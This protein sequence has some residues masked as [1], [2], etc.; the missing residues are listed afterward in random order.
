M[1]YLKILPGSL[2][3]LLPFTT[4]IPKLFPIRQAIMITV[5]AAN[6]EGPSM[7]MIVIVVVIVVCD[8][9]VVTL[10][11]LTEGI[12]LCTRY[13]A[14]VPDSA[15]AKLSKVSIFQVRRL[16]QVRRVCLRNIIERNQQQQFQ[17][18]TLEPGPYCLATNS[19]FIRI[20]SKQQVS[21]LVLSYTRLV[22]GER[23]PL[24]Q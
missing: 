5:S 9:A 23:S 19:F 14:S 12:E 16:L 3:P 6:F 24:V 22:L 18:H 17:Y 15:N 8:C 7:A 13:P 1:A 10:E 11:F 2:S 4:W 21:C 20:P